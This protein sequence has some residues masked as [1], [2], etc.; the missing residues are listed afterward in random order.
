LVPFFICIQ[1]IHFVA[2]WKLYIKANHKAWEALIP[3]Y[4]A[5]I[6]MKII[7]RPKWWVIL[8][9]V[10]IINQIM[11]PVIWVETIRSF[12]KNSKLDT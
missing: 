1:I 6:L 7:N 8:L 10:P 12:G 4:N 9:F 11:F 5:I 3:I 2:T